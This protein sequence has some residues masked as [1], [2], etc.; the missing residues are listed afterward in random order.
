MRKYHN[1]AKLI[2]I[3]LTTIAPD[4]LAR[5][6]WGIQTVGKIR[7]ADGQCSAMQG[8]AIVSLGSGIY[9]LSVV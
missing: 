8:S 9:M 5:V 1:N 4:L 6:S 3:L 7:T 2:L